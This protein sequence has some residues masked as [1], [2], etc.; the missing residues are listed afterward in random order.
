MFSP[1]GLKEAALDSPTFRATALHFA[2]QIEAI[3]RWL[4]G[5]T[6]SAIRPIAE[7]PSFEQAINAFLSSITPPLNI[8]E[9]AL[10]HDYTQLAVKKNA[11]CARDHW[12]AIIGLPKKWEHLAVE[13]IKTFIQGDLRSFKVLQPFL[14]QAK[15]LRIFPLQETRRALEQTQ[16]Q[17]DHLQARYSSQ[18]KS[19][20]PS[21]LRED[22]FQLHEAHKAYLKAS[23]DFA[24]QA[25]Q[26]R[27]TLDKLLVRISFDQ[28]RETKIVNDTNAAIF[29]KCGQ[30]M[31]RIRGWLHEMEN[32]DRFSRRE[33][34][35]A[36][37]QIEEAAELAARPSRELEDYSIATVPYLG[38]RAPPALKRANDKPFKPEK[39]GWLNL[40]TLTGKPTRTI[41]IR[42][43]AFLRNGVFGCLMPGT[44]AGGV[45]ESER[46]GVLLCS[47][48]L[49]FQEERRFCF[50]VKTKK[51]TIMLQAETQK[52][53]VGWIGAFE[54]AK[55]KAL[56]NPMS[57]GPPITGKIAIQDA[58]F[59][60]S[61]PL[62]PEFASDPSDSL[63]LNITDDLALSE[64]SGNQ[65][66]RDSLAIKS[67]GDLAGSR[68]STGLDGEV[69]GSREHA[70]RII[71][72]LDLHRRSNASGQQFV[73]SPSLAGA[74]PGLSCANAGAS[75]SNASMALP[76]TENDGARDN[77]SGHASREATA[78]SLVPP[79][80]VNP[81]T[82][83]SMSMAAVK[84]AIER[85]IT[86]GFADGTGELPSGMMANLWGSANWAALSTSEGEDSRLPEGG[87]PD[88]KES[89]PKRPASPMGFSKPAIASEL[90]APSDL[91]KSKSPRHRQTVSVDSDAAKLQRSLINA[92]YEYPSY[93]PQQLRVQN[94]Q[95]RLLFP[96]AKRDE[97]LVLVFRAT[98]S[99]N[100]QQDFPGRAYVTTSNMYFYSNHFGLVLITS[101]ALSNIMK[102][103]TAPGRDCDFLFLHIAPSTAD[104]TPGRITVKTFLEPL[105]LLQG[106]MSFLVKEAAVDKPQDLDTIIKTLIRMETDPPVRAPSMDSWEDVSLDTPAD[107]QSATGGNLSKR[108]MK[109]MRAAI[110]LERDYDIDPTKPS[111][112]KAVPGFKLPAQP[113]QYV[114]QGH[115]NLAAEKVI[116]ISSKALFHVLFGDKSAVW[117]LLLY[118]RMAQGLFSRLKLTELSV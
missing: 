111:H 40:R 69:S 14:F 44:R 93:Y 106:R 104:G 78:I 39:Q 107:I 54:V 2:E 74:V 19:K 90:E 71:Q 18:A 12:S 45:A 112:G 89:P 11:D 27:G 43:W 42:R 31:D 57:N 81:P 1:V 103:T 49:A 38:S 108:S 64:R 70:P 17:Y 8:S 22:A 58:A 46:I 65:P 63:T 96:N 61:Q 105:R 53:L 33:L 59:S 25:P 47:I 85:G 66:E 73:P 94:A 6:K 32:S 113:V 50:E 72:K 10:D 56:E 16:K 7:L 77:A 13:P 84:V 55:Q 83:T 115:L 23:M 82:P 20:E 26:V 88:G 118:E 28:W 97:S 91:S 48:R 41:W 62:V 67:G 24:I 9:A 87:M 36:R 3:E 117:Q 79:T 15:K 75:L 101:I 4:D 51:N 95:F 29:A 109:D 80:F 60:I 116:N 30:E 100:D 52:E 98:W 35:T 34:V 68:R 5:Y 102:V 99:S 110:Y 76:S 37:K 86:L 114:P 92:P 21:S